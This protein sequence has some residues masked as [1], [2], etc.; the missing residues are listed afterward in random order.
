MVY[1]I[2]GKVL[3]RSVSGKCPDTILPQLPMAA[4]LSSKREEKQDC[5]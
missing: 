1:N 5:K 4:I 2:Q 3:S